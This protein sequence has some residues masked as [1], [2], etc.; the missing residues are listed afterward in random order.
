MSSPGPERP[1]LCVHPRLALLVLGA[2]FAQL[3]NAPCCSS[4]RFAR[5]ETINRGWD[6]PSLQDDFCA[7]AMNVSGSTYSERIDK[8]IL[9][10][11]SMGNLIASGALASGRCNMAKN[12]HW[13]SIAAPMEGTK[14]SNCIEK[15]YP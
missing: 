6:H 3:C 9:V 10:A 2:G 4:V 7:A 5:I 14:S 13:I 1:Q 11:H 12:V 15:P 8:L